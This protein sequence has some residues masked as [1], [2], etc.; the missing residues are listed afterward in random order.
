MRPVSYGE[1]LGVLKRRLNSR[2]KKASLYPTLLPD[3]QPVAQEIR[4]VEE[5]KRSSIDLVLLGEEEVESLS[6]RIHALEDRYIPIYR[7]LLRLGFGGSFGSLGNDVFVLLTRCFGGFVAGHL[8][9]RKPI[10]PAG[11]DP[12]IINRDE[13][14]RIYNEIMKYCKRIGWIPPM[15]EAPA[16]NRNEFVLKTWKSS[17]PG[18]L[19]KVI[20]I[21]PFA[22]VYDALY[23]VVPAEEIEREKRE[24]EERDKKR[25]E[26]IEKVLA[27]GQLVFR[28]NEPFYGAYEVYE[29]SVSSL[30]GLSWLP[31]VDAISDVASRAVIVKN[32]DAFPRRSISISCP[33][34]YLHASKVLE[35]RNV[36]FSL[37]ASSRLCP[38]PRP[39]GMLVE[40]FH[41]DREWYYLIIFPKPSSQLPSVEKAKV[42][43]TKRRI[44]LVNP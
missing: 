9:E 24:L 35:E 5:L 14:E 23:A 31:V 39:L 41:I 19:E 30:K 21:D 10:V 34:S 25:A 43:R 37:V 11:P 38:L 36:S 12:M 15:A 18:Y 1:V 29:V 3:C 42:I 33:L 32:F 27:S 6:R 2:L 7:E 13:A 8:G 26:D 16:V 22:E 20:D 40:M 17:Y 28:R 44:V 4:A